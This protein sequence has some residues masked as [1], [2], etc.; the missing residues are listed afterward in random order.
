MVGGRWERE[1]GGGWRVEG[2]REGGGS[3][4]ASASASAGVR[5]RVISVGVIN[6]KCERVVGTGQDRIG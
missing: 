3:A 6:N 2:G 4:R 5:V 1:E